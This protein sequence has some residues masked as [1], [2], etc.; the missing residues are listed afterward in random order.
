MV[1]VGFIHLKPICSGQYL[2]KMDTEHHSW[3]ETGQQ[4]RSR[5]Q[6]NI[7][8]VVLILRLMDTYLILW[9]VLDTYS[10]GTECESRIA[11]C[12]FCCPKTLALLLRSFWTY[13]VPYFTHLA[14]GTSRIQEANP[15]WVEPLK[16]V[17][18]KAWYHKSFQS[19]MSESKT[20][21]A[22]V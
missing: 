7:R 21:A 17:L 4:T 15:S 12:S 5:H 3:F 6:H 22:H 2:S 1:K 20:Q 14:T 13:P 18:K 16:S 8:K 19:P 9:I 11:W 10:W